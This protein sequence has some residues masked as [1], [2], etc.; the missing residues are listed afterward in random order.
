MKEERKEERIRY[1]GKEEGCHLSFLIQPN[2]TTVF[3]FCGPPKAK[4]ISDC[5]AAYFAFSHSKI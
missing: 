5:H 2:K 1:Q 4:V 3:V